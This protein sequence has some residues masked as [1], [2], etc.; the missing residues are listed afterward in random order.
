LPIIFITAALVSMLLGAVAI[1]PHRYAYW[2]QRV[3]PRSL[4]AFCYLLQAA[5]YA[6]AGVLVAAG[7]DN[8]VNVSQAGGALLLGIAC[9]LA[10][11]GLA[12]IP[13]PPGT[14][15]HLRNPKSWL[16]RILNWI[17]QL[18]DFRALKEVTREIEALPQPED[19][20]ARMWDIYWNSYWTD[21]TVPATTKAAQYDLLD[22][23][24]AQIEEQTD[25]AD[26]TGRLRNFCIG[27][28]KRR[29]LG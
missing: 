9:G 26:G 18:L 5:T 6:A 4:L 19:L 27:E 16:G 23:G 22:K 25:V 11:H 10:P 21:E 29:H 15:H 2:W 13:V 8:A 28:I 7:A 17:T 24:V 20:I 14:V 3:R 12:A 1:E